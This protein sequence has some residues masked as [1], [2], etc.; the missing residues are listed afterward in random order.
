MGPFLAGIIYDSAGYYAVFGTILG[1]IA[2]DFLL[3]LAM[4][5]KHCKTQWETSES[6]SE[7][8]ES[9]RQADIW[10]PQERGKLSDRDHEI[11]PLLRQKSTRGESWFRV[12]FP[13]VTVLLQS[14]RLMAAVGGAFTQALLVTAFDPIL[15]LFVYRTFGWGPTGGGRS[16]QGSLYTS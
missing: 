4:I 10:E 12:R 2:F 13:T 3:R 7:D 14:P 9:V 1:I 5:E 11:T 16:F 6:N 8:N 15:P